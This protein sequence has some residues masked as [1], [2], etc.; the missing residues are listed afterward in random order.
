MVKLDYVKILK[1]LDEIPFGV[2]KNLLIDFLQGQ[3][4]NQLIIRNNLKQCRSFGSYQKSKG[5]LTG[6]INNLIVNNMIR[7]TSIPQNRFIKVMEITD[8]G[9]REINKPSLFKKKLSY[10]FKESR[11]IISEKERL[12]FDPLP[13]IQGYNDQQKKAIICKN[14]RTLCIAGAGSGKTTVLTKRIEYLMEYCYVKPE[15]ILAITF[16]RKARQ[17][18]KSRI[19]N[20][21]VSVETFNSFCERILRRYND[22]IYDKSVRMLSYRDR[23]RIIRK[24]L[25]SLQLSMD[26]ALLIYFPWAQRQG[27]TFDKMRNIF[28]N[29]I[30]Y[31]RDYLKFKKKKFRFGSHDVSDEHRTSYNM[32][33]G[34]S[35]YI[36]AYMRKNGLRDFADQLL[37]TLGFFEKHRDLIPDFEHILIDEY[38]DINST[39]I[40]LIDT[41]DAKNIFCVGDP[42]QSIY[43]WRGSDIKYILNFPDKYPGCDILTLSKNYRSTTAIVKLINNSIRDMGFL[44]LESSINKGKDIHLKKFGSEEEEFEFVTERI[45]VSNLPRKEIFVLVRTNRIL[46]DISKLMKEKG[47]DHLVKSDEIRRNADPGEDQVTLA[48]IHSIKGMEAEAVFLL[49]CTRNNFP[50]QGSDHPVVDLIKIDEYDKEEE[51]K[52]L[53]YV[54]MSRAKRSLY[55]TYT[56]SLTYFITKDMQRII[57]EKERK[58][59][60]KK[61]QKKDR[62]Y[63]LT[64]ITISRSNDLISILKEWRKKVSLASNVP[65]YCVFHNK[66]LMD[67]SKEMPRDL[68]ELKDIS[69]IGPMKIEKYGDQILKIVELYENSE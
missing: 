52:R 16:T 42:R 41:L 32:L 13:M 57:N 31:L 19:S 26:Q 56:R 50:C 24:A 10:N 14:S 4:G 39:Q 69:G 37:D 60:P 62:P 45:L 9:K 11:T 38:Q 12:L 40:E 8:K 66:T 64:P 17:E 33:V 43:G 44:D 34:I 30:Y 51:E 21:S 48:T 46:N 27:K 54:A 7:L 55:L 47:I 63:T 20:G 6:S 65:A 2:G 28:I 59:V 23:I 25:D 67:I 36:E 49:G 1:A 29:D 5:E 61:A 15:S 18:M 53:L 3:E 58:P 68:S 22:L 35:N